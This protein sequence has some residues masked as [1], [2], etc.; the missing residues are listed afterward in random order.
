M[1]S[2]IGKSL[3]IARAKFEKF[4]F[5]PDQTEQLLASGERDLRSETAHLK[6]LISSE[7]L[8]THKIDKSI[9]AIK[10]ILLNMGN[11]KDAE[12]MRELEN[13]N[14]DEKIDALRKILGV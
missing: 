13:E 4:G 2:L 5:S 8:D 6:S 3:N 10:G 9:H 11:E 1:D 7:S 12:N 14:I